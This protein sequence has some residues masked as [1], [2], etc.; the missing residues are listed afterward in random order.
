MDIKTVKTL[1][2]L[3]PLIRADPVHFPDSKTSRDG[4]M[5]LSISLALQPVMMF[6]ANNAKGS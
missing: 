4:Y 1:I 2:L 5:A 3:T 6:L